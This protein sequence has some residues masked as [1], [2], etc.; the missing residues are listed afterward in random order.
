MGSAESGQPRPGLHAERGRA[1]RC[2]GGAVFE[3]TGY[4]VLE[5]NFHCRGGEIDVVARKGEALVLVEGKARSA[6]EF[7]GPLD[8]VGPTKQ[9]R[10]IHDAYGYL[11]Q[12]G[13]HGAAAR[14]DLVG[15]R[16]DRAPP[17]VGLVENAFEVPA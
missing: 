14:F 9:R 16:L 2:A 11:F 6:D 17:E 3:K 4:K 13:L 8:A 12:N 5:T 10:L 15:V 1:G 7:G